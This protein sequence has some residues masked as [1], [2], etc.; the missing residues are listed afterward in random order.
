[1]TSAANAAQ[2]IGNTSTP[3]QI[4]QP[5]TDSNVPTTDADV[6]AV[7]M[8]LGDGIGYKSELNAAKTT[9]MA[10]NGKDDADGSKLKQA[11]IDYAVAKLATAIDKL[12]D[13]G[14]ITHA[15]ATTA[16]QRLL[17]KSGSTLDLNKS[18]YLQTASSNKANYETPWVEQTGLLSFLSGRANS[19]DKAAQYMSSA[20]TTA[21]AEADNYKYNPNAMVSYATSDQNN[22]TQTNSSGNTDDNDAENYTHTTPDNGAVTGCFGDTSAS[23]VT[24]VNAT[25]PIS[26]KAITKAYNNVQAIAYADQLT[27]IGKEKGLTDSEIN[28]TVSKFLR[29]HNYSGTGNFK[30]DVAAYAQLTG[31]TSDYNI[32]KTTNAALYNAQQA[33]QSATETTNQTDQNNTTTNAGNVGGASGG[34]SNPNTSGTTTQVPA[35]GTTVNTS[36]TSSTTTLTRNQI[37]DTNI[38][39]TLQ[40]IGAIQELKNAVN[41]STTANG[42]DDPDGSK[43]KQA[44]I[45]FVVAKAAKIIDGMAAKGSIT[46]DEA[47]T[48][49]QRLL[50][51]SG[52]SI[53]LNKSDYLETAA[54]DKAFY[55]TGWVDKPG[56]LG[57][58]SWAG[59][60]TETVDPKAAQYVSS[61]K[62]TISAAL[63]TSSF[64][65]SPTVGSSST[66]TT[67]SNNGNTTSNTSNTSST[68]N[69]TTGG[70]SSTGTSTGG[71][72]ETGAASS[73]SSPT[74]Y[75]G[76]TWYE[77]LAVALGKILDKQVDK[78]KEQV[79]KVEA[80]TA[81]DKA[82]NSGSSGGGDLLGNVAKAAVSSIPIIGSIFGGLFGGGGSSS[83]TTQSTAKTQ[84]SL[85]QAQVSE[86]ASMSTQFVSIINE[87]GSS[88]KTLA[89]KNA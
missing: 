41:T 18:D 6:D 79:K 36:S 55:E 30:R 33:G 22:T 3:S 48:A 67:T 20:N 8:Q 4:G 74:D 84:E 21:A 19:A 65:S 85:L 78:I 35:A 71:A 87:V 68:S 83:S 49:K 66:T 10:P 24:P 23:N 11:K 45:D 86:L 70:T 80:A 60:P 5:G 16:K 53:D 25:S 37:I 12:A 2:Y 1:M 58:G 63:N 76:L 72:S 54:H 43:L 26:T 31:D 15:Q 47:I 77:A 62:T 61:A 9:S 64:N 13:K 51:E 40:S 57:I 89:N 7:V 81:A 38:F 44:K 82:A 28:K 14:T 32:A 46:S 29:Q 39:T 56:F 59:R 88:S 52:S 69:T 27:K 75:T 42:K 17:E 50:S 73:D 34:Q